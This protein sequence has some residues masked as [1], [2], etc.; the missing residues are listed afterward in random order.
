MIP[1]PTR[2][3]VDKE[4]ADTGAVIV[5]VSQTYT[6]SKINANGAIKIGGSTISED[7]QAA[8]IDG[9]TVSAASN[10]VVVGGSTIPFSSIPISDSATRGTSSSKASMESSQPDS[11]SSADTSGESATQQTGS[12]GAAVTSSNSAPQSNIAT[13][14]WVSIAFACCLRLY[15]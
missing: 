9:V 11:H 5:V 12:D 7:G 10:G 2:T 8:T 6:V 4:H 14:L 3:A 13:G 15:I 1:R